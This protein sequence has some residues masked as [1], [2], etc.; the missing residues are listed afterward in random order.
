MRRW[1]ALIA[2]SA[3]LL[4]LATIL[5]VNWDTGGGKFLRLSPREAMIWLGGTG[6]GAAWLSWRKVKE[7]RRQLADLKLRDAERRAVSAIGLVEP[8]RQRD[9]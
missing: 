8:V 3:S 6:A 9:M 7:S 2:A 1:D 5:V 4:V